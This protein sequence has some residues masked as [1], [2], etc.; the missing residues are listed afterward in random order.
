MGLEGTIHDYRTATTA[1][2]VFAPPRPVASNFAKIKAALNQ[3][4]EGTKLDFAPKTVALPDSKFVVFHDDQLVVCVRQS[5]DSSNFELHSLAV[6]T[7]ILGEELVRHMIQ[8][9]PLCLVPIQ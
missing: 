2:A 6:D 4:L 8:S 3:A 9:S 1:N 7:S 5:S